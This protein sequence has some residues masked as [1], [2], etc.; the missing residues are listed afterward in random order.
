MKHRLPHVP[1]FLEFDVRSMHVP[2]QFVWP[3]G[4]VETQTPDV[5]RSAALQA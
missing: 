4:Q 3:V 1:Q 5:H 2:L